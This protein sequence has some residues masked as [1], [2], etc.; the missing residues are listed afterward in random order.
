[1]GPGHTK[2]IGGRMKLGQINEKT[3]STALTLTEKSRRKAERLIERYDQ[4]KLPIHERKYMIDD[5]EQTGLV[6]RLL[7]VDIFS[8]IVDI[9]TGYLV[10]IPVAINL[11]KERY[12]REASLFQKV[13]DKIVPGSS[14][15]KLDEDS[16]LL[17]RYGVINDIDLQNAE[18]EKYCSIAGYCGRLN[19]VSGTEIM[20]KTIKPSECSFMDDAAFYLYTMEEVT[21]NT[22]K[23]V[24]YCRAYDS[25]YM[26]EFKNDGG[27][28]LVGSPVAHQF[29]GIPLV[30]CKNNERANS[31][32]YNAI[33]LLDQIDRL[34]SDWAS[35]SEQ[36]RLAALIAMGKS[37][38][39]EN[40]TKE[41]K[42]KGAAF[43][44]DGT[45]MKYLTKEIPYEQ[46]LALIKYLREEAFYTTKT[47]N[48][49]DE[50]FA[51][52]LSGVALE[53]KFRPFEFKCMTKERYFNAFLRENYR[54]VCGIMSKFG[55]GDIAYSA[56]DFTFTR[57]YPK[58]LFEEAQ[59]QSLLDGK[60]P[61]KDRLKL[62]SFI[63]DPDKAARELE[64]EQGESLYNGSFSKTKTEGKNDPNEDIE[65][66]ESGYKES[67]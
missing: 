44:P 24:Y 45:D 2:K 47:P 57:N 53:Y 66:E 11:N 55:K 51:G 52:N 5:K 36:F 29:D 62:C 28:K 3:I 37:K 48:M 43:L 31:D 22:T 21:E 65:D 8:E 46:V 14:E 61:V 34:V 63:S 26:Y 15:K 20:S 16:Y 40:F 56:I 27:W 49:R 38:P 13:K 67:A 59:T 9:S 10:G 60:V 42:E 32:A 4:A 35:E 50:S 58:N 1:M 33:D 17:Q 25:K 39:N 12:N 19:Y 23:T 54:L 64:A 41:L 18:V 6:K 7:S 30:E